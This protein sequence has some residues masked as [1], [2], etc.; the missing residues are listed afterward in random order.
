[1]LS[2]FRRVDGNSIRPSAATSTFNTKVFFQMGTKLLVFTVHTKVS[3]GMNTF[4]VQEILGLAG[5]L[6]KGVAFVANR[7]EA[8]HK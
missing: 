6:F 4:S 3:R 2:K 7:L 1:M 8:R 5:A